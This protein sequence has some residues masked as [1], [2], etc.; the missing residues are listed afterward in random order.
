M[1]N[2]FIS[3]CIFDKDVVNEIR[4]SLK[5]QGHSPFIA[6]Q[7]AHPGQHIPKK[8]LSALNKSDAFIVIISH[9]SINSTW[10][11]QE[12]GYAI[13]RLP[14]IPIRIDDTTP[15]SLLQG[16]EYLNYSASILQK[17]GKIIELAIKNFQPRLKGQTNVC[18]EGPYELESGCYEDILLNVNVGDIITGRIEEIDGNEFDWYIINEANLINFKRS[19]GRHFNY[20]DGEENT[21]ASSIKR[22]I[23]KNLKGPWY[24][25]LT[26]YGKQKSRIIRVILQNG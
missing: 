21:S 3:H 26:L 7:E 4:D 25:I 12:I 13:G 19:G 6:I 20:I 1:A 16:V 11:Q 8:I 24:L 10:V 15:P 18:D 17:I 23:P 14:V 5:S 9:A 22:K 2:V